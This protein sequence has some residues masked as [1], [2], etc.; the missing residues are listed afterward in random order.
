MSY[1]QSWHNT[2]DERNIT[3]LNAKAESQEDK[4]LTYFRERPTR[5][6]TPFE[7]QKIVLPNCPITSVRRAI[8]NLTNKGELRKLPYKKTEKY[9][10]S[11]FQ[12]MYKHIQGRLFHE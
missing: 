3:E 8:T 12:W 10:V 6:F 9:G 1:P 2:T 7:V 11:N 4:V 5:A